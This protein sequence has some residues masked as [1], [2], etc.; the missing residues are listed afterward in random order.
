MPT[1]INDDLLARLAVHD[2]A[3]MTSLYDQLAPSLRGLVQQIISSPDEAETVLENLFL[4]LWKR[5]ELTGR[6]GE[7][8]SGVSLEAWLFVT[9]RRDAAQR[10][11]ER[12]RL[13]ILAAPAGEDLAVS[14]LPHS[15]KIGLLSSRLDLVNRSLAQLPKAQRQVL[16]LVL[17]EGLTEVEVAAV[18]KEPPGKMRDHLRAALSFVRQ[19]LHTLMG[20]WTA[21]I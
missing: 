16:D 4:R 8:Q 19:R 12:L 21:D 17:Y 9:A 18:L 10:R 7:G 20:T 13:P 11:R 3:A 2:T 5:A 6:V 15:R 14:W 1:E